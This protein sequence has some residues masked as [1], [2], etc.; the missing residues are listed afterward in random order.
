MKANSRFFTGALVALSIGAALSGISSAANAEPGDG[1]QR[2]RE[3]NGQRS[4]A[5]GR[6]GGWNRGERSS[7]GPAPSAPAA[8]QASPQNRSGWN[9]GERPTP[10]G[11]FGSGYGGGWQRHSQPS[12]PAQPVQNQFQSRP[13]PAPQVDNRMSGTTRWSEPPNRNRSYGDNRSPGDVQRDIRRDGNRDGNWDRNRDGRVENNRDGN[14]DRNRGG[15]WDRNRDGNW[16][17]NRSGGWDRNRDRNRAW[18][19]EHNWRQNWRNDN[20][21]NWRVYRDSHREVYRIGRYYPPYSSWSYRRLGIGFFLDRA[22]FGMNFWINDPW[23]YRLPDAYGPYRWVR[24]Y[25]DALLVDIYTG[26]V[27]DVIYDFFW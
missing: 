23:E 22:F 25:D 7:S 14:W 5:Q 2:G 24:Y 6:G 18:I 10:T 27:V 12:A 9:G 15:N 26:E 8:P 19:G 13:Q 16:D 11:G 1:W 3:G 21:Y 20:R 17:R 4:E